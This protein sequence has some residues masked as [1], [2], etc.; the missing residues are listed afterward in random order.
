MRLLVWSVRLSLFR[1]FLFG[2]VHS[3]EGLGLDALEMFGRKDAAEHHLSAP[4]S[5]WFEGVEWGRW[6]EGWHVLDYEWPSRGTTEYVSGTNKELLVLDRRS[7]QKTDVSIEE[8][9]LES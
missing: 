7:T 5:I 9:Q 8:R 2:G 1:A 3:Q 6:V 4:Q